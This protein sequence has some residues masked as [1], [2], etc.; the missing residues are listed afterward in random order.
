MATLINA[1]NATAL[2]ARP[3][4]V[5]TRCVMDTTDPDIQFDKNGVCNHCHARDRAVARHVH[6]REI[7]RTELQKLVARIKRE[8][9]KKQYDCVIGV[10]GG[11]D[12]TFVAYQVKKRACAPWLCIW[13]TAGIQNWP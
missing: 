8:S 3:Y 6:T 12:S 11:V 10:S 9:A 13:I 4:Q 1:E 7:A 2:G 5:C